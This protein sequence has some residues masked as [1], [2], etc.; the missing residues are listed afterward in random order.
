M[1]RPEILPPSAA[2]LEPARRELEL[3]AMIPL[4]GELSHIPSFKSAIVF[5]LD[6]LHNHS[7]GAVA[8]A[9]APGIN[10]VFTEKS[11][12]GHRIDTNPAT[13]T[14]GDTFNTRRSQLKPSLMNPD[15]HVVWGAY[16][17]PS[18]E[19]SASVLQLAFDRL[20]TLPSEKTLADVWKKHQGP[21]TD[22]TE[23]LILANIDRLSLSND[24]LLDTPDTPNAFVIKW[25]ITKSTE[26]VHRHYP[27]FRQYIEELEQHI[28]LL[29][30][31]Y[32]GRIVSYNGDGQNIVVDIPDVI[33]RNNPYEIGIYGQRTAAPLIRA[34]RKAH[35]QIASSYVELSPTIRIGLDL[36]HVELSEMG[37]ETGLV[38]WNAAETIDSIPRDKSGSRTT[39]M[40]RLALTSARQNK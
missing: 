33:N 7:A 40:A 24:L 19:K 12:V 17:A 13:T 8:H 38:F 3:D 5:T 30:Q 28:N 26:M 10:D 39:R 36:G 2:R 6:G 37:E 14:V 32:S 21:I 18:G 20:Q 23:A 35:K 27:L 29:V 34:I 11:I 1:N 16:M 22:A 15:G 4:V 25:D 9:H 31:A